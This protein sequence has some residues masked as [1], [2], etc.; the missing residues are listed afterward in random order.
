MDNSVKFEYLIDD[1]KYLIN[2]EISE[3]L[4]DE[5][6]GGGKNITYKISEGISLRNFRK[7]SEEKNEKFINFLFLNKIEEKLK[8]LNLELLVTHYEFNYVWDLSNR[9]NLHLLILNSPKNK[10]NYEFNFSEKN[11]EFN[12]SPKF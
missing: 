5:P 3:Y 1:K 12:F 9:D 4:I 2:K 6:C 11:K 7:L 8:F 10:K